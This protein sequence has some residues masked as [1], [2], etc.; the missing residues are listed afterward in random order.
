MSGCGIY[1]NGKHHAVHHIDYD[2]ENNEDWNLMTLCNCCH[3]KTN[4]NR[5]YW[6]NLFKQN[7]NE[8]GIQCPV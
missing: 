6:K 3:M 7:L 5:E 8:R 1:E 2:K 4:F